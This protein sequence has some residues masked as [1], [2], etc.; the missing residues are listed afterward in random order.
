MR[1]GAFAVSRDS[2][3]HTYAFYALP[4]GGW[5][6]VTTFD[7][8]VHG[9]ALD[10]PAKARELVLSGRAF[11]DL[12][13]QRLREGKPIPPGIRAHSNLIVLLPGALG[14]CVDDVVRAG[15]RSVGGFGGGS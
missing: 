15:G 14:S 9:P 12:A 13:L 7:P 5:D 4:L 1:G 6:A 2:V 3:P 8:A 11:S 10:D